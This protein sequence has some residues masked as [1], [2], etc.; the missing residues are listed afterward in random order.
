M[1]TLIQNVKILVDGKVELTSCSLSPEAVS[2]GVFSDHSAFDRVI[3]GHADFFLL[4]GLADVHVHLREPGFSQKETIK[5]GTKA[6]A[7]GGYTCLCAM[8]NLS[9]A[10]D[11]KEHLAKE[12]SLI[13]KDALVDVLPY[14]TITKG[15]S[16][17]EEL[18]DLDEMAPLAVAF[19]DDG[20]GVQTEE[21]MREAMKKAKSLGKMIVAHCE[22]ESLMGGKHIHAGKWAEEHNICGISSESEWKQV[23][24]D[25]KL[26]E[27]IGCA[28]HICHI[29]TKESVALLR[30]AKK[31]GVNATGETGPHYLVLCDE[32]LQ[33]EGRFKMNPPLRSAK[34]R[35]ALIEGILD[36]TI[37]MI[38]TDHAPHT[39][40]EKGKGLLGSL[41]GVVGLETAFSVLYTHLVDKGILSLSDLV[42]LMSENPRRRFSL[43]DGETDWFLFDPTADWVIDPNKF[44]SMGKATPFAG[45]TVKGAIRATFRKGECIWNSIEN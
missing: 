6:A 3:D 20:K 28:Y 2:F 39:A 29:S 30:E 15:G 21:L 45:M 1:R 11:S 14:G 34:D 42:R 18:A 35:Q 40:E 12:L 13:E 36:G 43:P 5:T 26:A 25:L 16:G 23:E 7:A 33:D 4:P 10:P 32:D 24:R 38:A 27:E 22:D 31:R 19:T 17:R 9:P 8:P 44:V 37:D 41:M